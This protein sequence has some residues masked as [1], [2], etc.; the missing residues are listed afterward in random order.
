MKNLETYLEED[1]NRNV[2]EHILRVNYIDGTG[3][4][5]IYIHPSN[6]GGSTLDFIVDGNNLIQTGETK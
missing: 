3:K 5:H 2:I 6:V 1:Y 4:I